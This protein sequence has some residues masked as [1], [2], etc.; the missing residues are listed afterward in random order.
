[1]D[2]LSDMVIRH[3]SRSPAPPWVMGTASA[4]SMSTK[5]FQS[6]NCYA[7]QRHLVSTE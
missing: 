2:A 4:E 6:T 1:M 5:E 7:K 3:G